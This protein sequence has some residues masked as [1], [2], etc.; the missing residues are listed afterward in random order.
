MNLGTDGMQPQV[1]GSATLQ[2]SSRGQ[3]QVPLGGSLT[4]SQ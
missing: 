1:Q 4:G 2:T 3:Q